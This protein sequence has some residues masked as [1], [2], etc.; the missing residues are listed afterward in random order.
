MAK[1]VLSPL[2]KA[3]REFFLK[4]LDEFGVKTQANLDYEKKKEFFNRI[5][6]GWKQ[7]KKEITNVPSEKPITAITPK[8]SV[9]PST[10]AY[11]THPKYSRASSHVAP[12]KPPKSSIASETTIP[13]EP[14]IVIKELIKSEANPEQTDDLRIKYIPNQIFSQEQLYKYP[15]VKM[16]TEGSHIKLPR[17]GRSNQRGYKEKAFYNLIQ[18]S[19]PEIEI[20]TE[21]HIAIP[22]FN[23]PYEPDIALIDKNLNLYI[24]I[25]IDE[26]YDGYYRFPTHEEGKDEIRDLFFTESGWIVI[27]FTE[28]Q[29]HKQGNQ[30]IAYIKNVLNSIYNNSEVKTSNIVEEVQWDYQQAIRWEKEYYREKYLG[31]EKFGKQKLIKEVIVDSKENETIENTIARTEIYKPERSDNGVS[32]EE[33][34]HRYRHPLDLTGNAEYIS[35]TTLIER[36]FPFDSERYIKGK[37]KKENREEKDVLD[38]FIKNRDEAAEKGTYIHEQIEKFLVGE[39]HDD[40][41]KEFKLFKNFYNDVI[42]TNGFEFV[43][44]EKRIV[45][46]MY[47]LAGTVDA[48]FKKPNKDDY[49]VLDWKRSKKLVIDG[50]PKKYG[51]GYALSELSDLDNSSYYKYSLQVNIYKYIL[52]NKYGYSVSSMKLIVLHEKYDTYYI[53]PLNKMIPEV[54]VIINSINH[55]I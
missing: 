9:A 51:Y 3:Y 42:V 45:F 37:A 55:K 31:I 13:I 35:V 24:D 47:N 10:S 38:E 50:N 20:N 54:E 27:R 39:K 18:S 41:L 22:Y 46:D 17:E 28:R 15:V 36:F 48:I 7:I 33:E 32:F 52:E 23:R 14:S 53:I 6:V 1:R 29:V 4:M 44:A 25:E 19:I 43:E 21:L 26:P 2:Q 12:S 11:S 16:P 34:T 30:C 8:S 40:N 49:I 5:K